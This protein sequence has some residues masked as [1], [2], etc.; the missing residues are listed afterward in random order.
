MRPNFSSHHQRTLMALA[1][2][3]ALGAAALAQTSAPSLADSSARADNYYAAGNHIEITTP[4]PRDVIVAGRQIDI[5]QPVAGDVLAA[6]WRI[7]LTGR[8]DDDVRIAGAEVLV[9]APVTGDLTVAGGD[10][11]VGRDAHVSG[12]S[13]ITGGTVRIEGILEREL[14]IA[15]ASVQLAGE[16]HQPVEVVAD[17]LEISPSARVLAPLTYKG[18]AEALISEGAVVNGPITFDRIPAREVRRARAFPVVSSLF[19]AIH[20]FLAGLLVVI[21]APRVEES[22]VATLRTR[23]GPSLLAGFVMLVTIPVAVVLLILSVLGLAIGLTLAAVYAVGLLAGVLVTAFFVG[24]VEAKLFKTGPIVTRGQ[25]ALLL[26]AGVL[27]LA[28]L[29]SLL[30]GFVV[31]VS[32][33]FGVG[34]L[35]LWLYAAYGRLSQPSTV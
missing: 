5:S 13:W 15:G 7:T 9:N 24:D 25:Q 16:I 26:L 22:I 32:M 19:F 12:R 11:R 6:G 10:V 2:G 29:R 14:H 4:M 23:P 34:A 17:R 31:F 18:P 3:L 8:A 33:L 28:L 27:T 35:T 20:V 1:V 21:F 30:G